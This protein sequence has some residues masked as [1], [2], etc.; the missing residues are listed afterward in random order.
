MITGTL[1]IAFQKH[2]CDEL[3]EGK[4]M[5]HA[6]FLPYLCNRLLVS[7]CTFKQTCFG[8]SSLEKNCVLKRRCGKLK[9]QL[10]Q[11]LYVLKCSLYH[12]YNN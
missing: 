1:Y 10:I 9:K 6:Q 2:N 11:P 12:N 7:L 3:T 5:R 4:M 8:L